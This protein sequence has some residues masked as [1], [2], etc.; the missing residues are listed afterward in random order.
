[1]W[2]ELIGR[3]ASSESVQEGL[4]AAAQALNDLGAHEE[5]AELLFGR[6][7]KALESES[8]LLR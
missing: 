5:A 3:D 6:A 1:M 8:H 2:S 7:V 4:L